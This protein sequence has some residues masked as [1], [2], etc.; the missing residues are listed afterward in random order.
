M[1]VFKILDELTTRLLSINKSIYHSTGKA[2]RLAV[3]MND[4]VLTS[5]QHAILYSSED[6]SA[7]STFMSEGEIMGYPVYPVSDKSG[8]HP[9][10]T[11][12][13]LLEEGIFNENHGSTPSVTINRLSGDH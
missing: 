12:V 3:Y 8:G 10:F 1:L 2:P 4:E 13:H 11:I 9:P 7:I 6:S 5:M